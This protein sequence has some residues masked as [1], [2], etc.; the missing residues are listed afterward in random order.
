MKT[1]HDVGKIFIRY[2]NIDGLFYSTGFVV[3]KNT[4]M[5][6]AHS[7]LARN[8]PISLCLFVPAFDAGDAPYGIFEMSGF[9]VPQAFNIGKDEKKLLCNVAFIHLKEYGDRK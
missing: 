6:T 5:T 2:K 8:E 9:E 7:L 4:V 3:A 1:E